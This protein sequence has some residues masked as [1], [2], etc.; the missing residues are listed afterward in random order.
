MLW[1]RHRR[2]P[3]HWSRKDLLLAEAYSMYLDGLCSG[4]GQ[5][6]IHSYD[7]FNA[8]EFQLKSDAF[9]LACEQREMEQSKPAAGEKRYIVNMMGMPDKLEK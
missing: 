5:P 3:Q 7:G 6:A 9:C 1:G 8:G 2:R 4:C